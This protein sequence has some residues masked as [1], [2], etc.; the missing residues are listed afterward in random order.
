VHLTNLAGDGS[1]WVWAQEPSDAKTNAAISP[2]PSVQLEDQYGNK[3]PYAG[4]GVGL[5]IDTGPGAGSTIALALTNAN[6]I[7][8]FPNLT[9]DT[10]G[11]YTIK[12]HSNGLTDSPDSVGFTI[13]SESQPFQIAGN[14]I[15]QV[16][17]GGP[18]VPI[19]LVFTDPN[20]S[21]IT[22]SSVTVTITGTSAASCSMGNFSIP[23]QLTAQPVIPANSTK[24]LSDLGIP[25]SQWPTLRMLDNGNQE[26]CKTAT[27]NLSYDGSAAG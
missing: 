26:L 18:D 16:Y 8:T 5:Q 21:P 25:Q 12:A 20:S 4:H 3:A 11:T 14:A 27:V 23:Q 17:P 9:F 15:D 19:N 1:Q 22:V 10:A 6:G 24:S 7:A 13:T 2:V